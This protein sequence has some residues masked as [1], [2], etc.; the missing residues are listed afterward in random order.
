MDF[1]YGEMVEPPEDFVP[2]EMWPEF[3]AIANPL[4]GWSREWVGENPRGFR[5]SV[6]PFCFEQYIGDVEPDLKKSNEGDLARN[7]LIGWKRISRKETPQGWHALYSKDPWRIDGFHLLENDYDRKWSHGVRDDLRVWTKFSQKEK[8]K[9]ENIPIES[10]ISGYMNSTVVKKA[11]VIALKQVMRKYSMRDAGVKPQLLGVRN[12]KSGE[13]I[14]GMATYYSDKYKHS[15]YDCPFIT[16]EGRSTRAMIGLMAHWFSDS[17][18][19]GSKMQIFTTFW[20]PGRPE[21]WKGFSQFKSYFNLKYVAYP[22]EILR[23]ARG[24]F[25]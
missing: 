2:P 25:F 9:I 22:P 1:P 3:G 6:W 21:S 16:P 13:I 15:A 4:N 23:F 24:K 17:L 12:R 11:G 18:M 14:A 8:Y 19:R 20:H 10:F 7:R 5:W